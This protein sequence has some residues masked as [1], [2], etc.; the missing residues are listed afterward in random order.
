M[1]KEQQLLGSFGQRQ[2]NFIS[3]R[4]NSSNDLTQHFQA[5]NWKF[6]KKLDQYFCRLSRNVFHRLSQI[7]FPLIKTDL[8]KDRKQK[9]G[10][11]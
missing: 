5:A 11:G 9:L 8:A 10:G 6:R 3:I 7:R 4:S 2:R 1:K